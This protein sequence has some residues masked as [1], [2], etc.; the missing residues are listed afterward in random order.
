MSFQ[1]LLKTSF[2]FQGLKVY[3]NPDFSVENST[4]EMLDSDNGEMSTRKVVKIVV[5]LFGAAFIW[6]SVCCTK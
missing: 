5:P 3:E 4:S 6:C 1:G 2:S